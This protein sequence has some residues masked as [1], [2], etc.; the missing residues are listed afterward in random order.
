MTK[1]Q[2][3]QLFEERKVRKKKEFKHR[4]IITD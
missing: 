2:T 4:Q 3:I 1:K